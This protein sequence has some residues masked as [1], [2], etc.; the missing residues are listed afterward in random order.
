MKIFINN[1]TEVNNPD[2]N[3]YFR[4]ESV[5]S[6]GLLCELNTLVTFYDKG[7]SLAYLPIRLKC[8]CN[9]FCLRLAGTKYG[10]MKTRKSSFLTCTFEDYDDKMFKPTS[11]HNML[12]D[13]DVTGNSLNINYT[14]KNHDCHEHSSYGCLAAK[15]TR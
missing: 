8:Y 9:V 15:L 10:I 13:H 14:N 3:V 1:H 5:S 4:E 6:F 7:I 11:F 12:F 2:I